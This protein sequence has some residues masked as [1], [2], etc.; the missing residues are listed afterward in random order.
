VPMVFAGLFLLAG[1][2]VALY[3]I[4]ALVERRTTGWAQRKNDMAMA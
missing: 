3:A 1:M 2:G 4:S